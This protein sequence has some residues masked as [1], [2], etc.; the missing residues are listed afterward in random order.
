MSRT[1]RQSWLEKLREATLQKWSGDVELFYKNERLGLIMLHE[2]RVAWA[3]C[4][5]Q[6]EDLGSFLSRIGKVDREQLS[7][8]RAQYAKHQGKRKLGALLEESGCISRS[9]L[10]RCLLLHVRMA[11]RCLMRQAGLTLRELSHPVI[12][13][14]EFTFSI[15]EV[16]NSSVPSNPA[17]LAPWQESEPLSLLSELGGYRAS[18]ILSREGEVIAAHSNSDE[19]A[20]V[21]SAAAIASL[22]ESAS[23]FSETMEL[24]GLSLLIMDCS[25]G[26]MLSTW[27]DN[28]AELLTMVLLDEGANIGMAKYKLNATLERIVAGLAAAVD[29]DQSTSIAI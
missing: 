9:V 14:R 10:R 3:V 13:D 22:I 4:K 17:L 8:I 28:N 24:G 25:K 7:F 19:F 20:T 26:T 21:S 12:A 6:P 11:V 27:L 2:G 5:Y 29:T 1:T 18:V 16:T 15:E 23:R